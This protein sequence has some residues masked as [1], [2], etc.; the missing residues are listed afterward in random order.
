MADAHATHDLLAVAEAADRGG[1]LP[2]DLA[3]CPDCRA[4]LADLVA[5]AAAVPTAALPTRPR[6]YILTATDAARLHRG[7]WRRWLGA[8]G[9]SRD[10]VTRPLALGFT[11]LGLAGLLFAT[12]PGTLSGDA[13]SPASA[14]ESVGAGPSAV[15]APS[16]APVVGA[17]DVVGSLQGTAGP[18]ATKSDDGGVFT[19]GDLG[20]GRATDGQNGAELQ[21]PDGLSIR[22]DVSGMSVL[23]VTA[24]T[25]LI[26]GLGL[27]ALRWSV[28]RFGNG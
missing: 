7:G 18:E 26:V 27:F 8:I 14:P 25:L 10:A 2:T 23:A 28:R 3:A 24:G 11:T 1:R 17:P 15:G 5:I 4:L 12:I 19:G 9:S 21:G 13:A 22:D 6:A 20:E 16:A